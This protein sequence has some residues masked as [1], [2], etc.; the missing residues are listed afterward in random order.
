MY[1][2]NIT[3]Q[4]LGLIIQLGHNPG[5]PCRAPACSSRSFVVIHT[6]GLHPVNIQFCQCGQLRD[7]GARIQQLLRYKLFPATV[8]DPSTCC[9]FELLEHFHLL[10]LQSKISLYDFYSTLEK[11]T[12]N[13]GLGVSYVGENCL[14]YISALIKLI[15]PETTVYVDRPVMEIP[16]AP[17][18]SWPRSRTRRCA[19][20]AAG[21]TRYPMYS[22]SEAWVQ[23]SG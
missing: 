16:K 20:N 12:D 22:M 8:T 4:D 14:V 1:F 19:W 5:N 23:Y 7:S 9:T 18:T 15:E 6:N 21:G 13:T 2:E 17:Q 11:L 3:L 10:T